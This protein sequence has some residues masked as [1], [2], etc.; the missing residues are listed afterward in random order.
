M[1]DQ[2]ITKCWG[3]DAAKK[4]LVPRMDIISSVSEHYQMYGQLGNFHKIVNVIIFDE[5]KTAH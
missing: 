5:D 4:N 1:L 3:L 2:T